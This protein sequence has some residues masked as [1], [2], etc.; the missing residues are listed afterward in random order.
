M[1]SAEPQPPQRR[2]P[3]LWHR[4]TKPA[5]AAA[6]ADDVISRLVGVGNAPPPDRAPIALHR[7]RV[8][9][10]VHVFRSDS[11]GKIAH[12]HR[13]NVRRRSKRVCPPYFST[14]LGNHSEISGT[15]VTS[16]STTNITP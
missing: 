10:A 16:I 5:R 12:S 1:N 8:A 15:Y 2:R 13:K 4:W 11:V 14:H 6:S 3:R 9:H 7:R